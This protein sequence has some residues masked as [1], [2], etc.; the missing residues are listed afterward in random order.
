M[1]NMGF[2]QNRPILECAI[3]VHRIILKFNPESQRSP[4]TDAEHLL[5]VNKATI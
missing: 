4:S 5:H 2:K 1:K 3:Y